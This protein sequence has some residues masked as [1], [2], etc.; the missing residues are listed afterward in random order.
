M[1]EGQS[2]SKISGQKVNRSQ[3]TI[4]KR[5]PAKNSL[6]EQKAGQN[7]DLLDAKID[8]VNHNQAYQSR[9]E[10]QKPAPGWKSTQRSLEFTSGLMT[11][12]ALSRTTVE[13]QGY[14]RESRQAYANDCDDNNGASSPDHKDMNASFAQDASCEVLGN[15]SGVQPSRTNPIANAQIMDAP[16]SGPDTSAK[17]KKK[18][19]GKDRYSHQAS[20]RHHREQTHAA[21]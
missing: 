12:N 15:V 7:E 14:G 20:D 16:R 4:Y 11:Q 9:L 6:Q 21:I 19:M 8:I 17:R 13:E 2:A 1:K 10:T 18:A 5:T 3:Y